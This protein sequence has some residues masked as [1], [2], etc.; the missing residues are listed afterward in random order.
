[1]TTIPDD[2]RVTVE[3]L[4]GAIRAFARR[5]RS[6]QV[7]IVVNACLDAREQEKALAHE[8]EHVKR[9]DFDRDDPVESIEGSL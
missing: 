6:G 2:I 9:N 1:M 5:M 8:I 3:P 7:C 4:P